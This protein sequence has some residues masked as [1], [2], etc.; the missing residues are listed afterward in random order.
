MDNAETLLGATRRLPLVPAVADAVIKAT[1]F[2][3]FC[4]GVC[5]LPY[6]CAGMQR[7][8]GRGA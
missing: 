8:W 7:G 3:H 4:A 1:F 5:V 2:A 6:V